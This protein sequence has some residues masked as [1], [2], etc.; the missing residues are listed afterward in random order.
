MGKISVINA[1]DY[2]IKENEKQT[3]CTL[4]YIQNRALLL[5]RWSILILNLEIARMAKKFSVVTLNETLNTNTGDYETFLK[6]KDWKKENIY[7]FANERKYFSHI[8]V[9]AYMTVCI[10]S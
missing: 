3:I 1:I 7:T 8:R 10:H 2:K 4:R 5:R 6:K 9:N